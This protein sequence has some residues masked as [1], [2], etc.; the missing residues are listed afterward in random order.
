MSFEGDKVV[1][2]L[3]RIVCVPLKYLIPMPDIQEAKCFELKVQFFLPDAIFF[4]LTTGA[5]FVCF[6]T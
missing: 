2:A 5:I 4:L 1:L 3:Y 6:L